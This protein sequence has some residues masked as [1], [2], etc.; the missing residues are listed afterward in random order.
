[1]PDPARFMEVC[2]TLILTAV[3]AAQGQHPRVAVFAEDVHLLWERGNPEA[4]IKVEKLCNKLVELYDV[5]IMCGYSL[6]RGRG[7]MDDHFFQ[8]LCAEHS[9]VYL[10]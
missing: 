8:Q 10:Q 2:G 9:A 4:V 5:D 6:G 1:M 7:G 3:K